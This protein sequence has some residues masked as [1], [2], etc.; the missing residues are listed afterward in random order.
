MKNP[1]SPEEK[2]KPWGV[3]FLALVPA[4]YGVYLTLGVWLI[5]RPYLLSGANPMPVLYDTVTYVRSSHGQT[6]F[7]QAVGMR[8]KDGKRV[9]VY[10]SSIRDRFPERSLNDLQDTINQLGLNV[11]TYFLKSDKRAFVIKNDTRPD[12]NKVCL[13][14]TITYSFLSIP[15][16]LLFLYLQLRKLYYR[17]WYLPRY[18]DKADSDL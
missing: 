15:F 14:Y 12:I 5:D 2:S 13:G 8:L 10:L 11:N 3:L 6:G 17:Y 1:Y 9:A 4:F 18:G 16:W 7:R